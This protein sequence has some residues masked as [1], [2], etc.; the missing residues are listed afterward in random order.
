MLEH[1]E[2]KVCSVKAWSEQHQTPI[3][4]PHLH[5]LVEPQ[6]MQNGGGPYLGHVRL[7]CIQPVPCGSR[8]GVGIG[9]R[10]SSTSVLHPCWGRLP[11]HYTHRRPGAPMPATCVDPPL[12]NVLQPR[13]H[14]LALL[15]CQRLGLCFQPCP[16][17]ID[18]LHR[19]QA[20]AAVALPI[21]NRRRSPQGS[22]RPRAM[23]PAW[24]NPWG[25]LARRGCCL[26]SCCTPS[27]AAQPC[28][29]TPHLQSGHV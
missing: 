18:A 6:A 21:S 15:V 20:A 4:A 17:S 27:T 3:Q 26:P 9:H 13:L 23:G 11:A 29:R 24:P 5:L 7:Q 12:I 8:D 28:C 1:R 16:L 22:R 25:K 2:V 10:H 14:L 19:L